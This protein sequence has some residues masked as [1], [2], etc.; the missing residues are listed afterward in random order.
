[1]RQADSMTGFRLAV[2]MIRP[3]NL[4]FRQ[5]LVRNCP[6]IRNCLHYLA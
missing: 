3:K 2:Q 6:A 1:M 4:G 5:L